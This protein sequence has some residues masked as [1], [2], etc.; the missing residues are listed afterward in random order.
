MI[1]NRRHL[2]T[3][4]DCNRHINLLGITDDRGRKKTYIFF[5][6]SNGKGPPPTLGV[7]E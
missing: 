3:N 6:R 2:N 4:T 5:G 7:D 1:R